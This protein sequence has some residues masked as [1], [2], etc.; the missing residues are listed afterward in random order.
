MNY[1]RIISLILTIILMLSSVTNI[2][3][4]SATGTE[5]DEPVS[6]LDYNIT[7]ILMSD[8]FESYVEGTQIPA[9]GNIYAR[10]DNTQWVFNSGVAV[11]EKITGNQIAKLTSSDG[12]AM[13][14]TK[15]FDFNQ[16]DPVDMNI[17]ARV[18]P[19]E[20]TS[21][22][23]VR[24]Y[25]QPTQ[26]VI[27]FQAANGTL[28]CY[29]TE[30]G[31]IEMDKWH[32]VEIKFDFSNDRAATYLNGVLVAE[33]KSLIN[34]GVRFSYT[35]VAFQSTVSAGASAYWD[36]VFIRELYAKNPEN[37][38]ET[39]NN[40]DK[41][42]GV[43]PRLFATANDFENMKRMASC[44][45]SEE[46]EALIVKADEMAETEPPEWTTDGSAEQLWLRTVGI[47]IT[48]SLLAYKLT[49]E[50]KYKETAE[51]FAKK[52]I[53]YP[54]WGYGSSANNDLA[55]A[56][57]FVAISCY[58]D[59]LYDEL[60]NEEKTAIVNELIT[61][62]TVMS[63][64]SWYNFAYLQN[65]LWISMTGLYAC[66]AAIYDVYEP[67]VKWFGIADMRWKGSLFYL[68]KETADGSSHEGYGY[69]EYGLSF[70]AHYLDI[71]KEFFNYDFSN[72]AYFKNAYKY[73]TNVWMP[74][75][76]DENG[77]VFVMA[78]G[79]ATMD[80]GVSSIASVAQLA[81][82]TGSGENQWLVN[83]WR[84]KINDTNGNKD[85][86][87]L[88][89]WYDEGL[90][91]VPPEKQNRSNDELLEHLGFFFS[92]TGW[93]D[94]STVFSYRCGSTFGDYVVENPATYDLGRGHQHGD[95][96]SPWIW[97]RGENLIYESGYGNTD[98][99]AHSTL[100][101]N[102]VGQ[103]LTQDTQKRPA[104]ILKV[105]TQ[106]NLTYSVGDGTG[107]Y[108]PELGLEKFHRHFIYLKP[109]ILIYV[110][111][112]KT[113]EGETEIPLEL[114]VFPKP[115]DFYA[116]SDGRY[117][118]VGD[119]TKFYIHPADMQDGVV[120]ACGSLKKGNTS[121]VGV[122]VTTNNSK[123]I[124]PT[125]ISWNDKDKEP[126]KV[127]V[128]RKGERIFEFYTNRDKIVLDLD[129]MNVTHE[130]IKTGDIALKLN[131]VLVDGD[132]LATLGDD[133]RFY[134]E[135]DEIAEVFGFDAEINGN[136][137]TLSK[138]NMKTVMTVGANTVTMNN[139]EMTMDAV[140]YV[141]GDNVMVPVRYALQGFG[142]G[143]DYL[144]TDKVLAFRSNA[145]FSE[146][147]L[148]S[149]AANGKGIEIVDGVYDYSVTTFG[150]DAQISAITKE[151][152]TKVE[153]TN[154]G[155]DGIS[156]IKTTSADGL[157][158]NTYTV[159]V[160]LVKGIGNVGIY[161]MNYSESD[162]N[163][164]ENA[165]DGDVNTRWAASGIGQWIFMD[166]GREVKLDSML[167]AYSYGNQRKEYFDIQV[168]DDGQNWTT[169]GQFNSSGT[170]TSP[171]KYPMNGIETRYVRF[172]SRGQGQGGWTSVGEI[173]FVR[174]E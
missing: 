163:V 109:D 6:G 28:S 95:V 50:Q 65:H 35:V 104:K 119:N 34:E 37:W 51:R 12:A 2:S 107:Q 54:S 142:I 90:K 108:V 168:S 145:D 146:A 132:Y 62:G 8:D 157:N 155:M 16:T 162:G 49:G 124:Q 144:E 30:I 67:A 72:H 11:K 115:Q 88:F 77:K 98:S 165:F 15:A 38:E 159:N 103:D 99:S 82:I 46:Y 89:L 76:Y 40:L 68:G 117:S 3:V 133:Y 143:V 64:G 56:D 130:K 69:Y 80:Q 151:S 122:S 87:K 31:D 174:A 154:G 147:G 91:E 55:A 45:L 23:S 14:M 20:G 48:T 75:S 92:R 94:D 134:M 136:I 85:L 114:R 86:E 150:Y 153:I 59:W 57:M 164:G 74:G 96:N 101:V 152:S 10:G 47:T 42:A 39:G 126:V 112:I 84:D 70:L 4:F 79:D 111:D 61:R 22:I 44:E 170:T 43:H 138:D 66:A 52:G 127:D 173:G 83:H 97:T 169:I 36:D 113:T 5:T 116:E 106:E 139:K 100:L 13:N 32:E 149:I 58:Y 81:H 1:K 53:S 156:I 171:E 63:N 121:G 148:K 120:S 41:L 33:K 60:S 123:L 17:K 21:L 18:K 129:S 25:S 135:A 161:G 73:I 158:S 26:T 29:G 118:F 110:D 7:N 19:M 24:Q 125:I 27:P 78:Y 93:E 160:S 167:V 128:V 131:G 9:T 141:I 105:D 140:P 71:A 172:W 137:V 166:L 102:G